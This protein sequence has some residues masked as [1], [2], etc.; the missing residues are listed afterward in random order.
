M[1]KV[2]SILFCAVFFG[3][4]VFFSAGMLLPGAIDPSEDS[5]VIPQFINE[6]GINSDF[7]NEF[8]EWFSKNFAF[9]DSVTDL[10]SSLKM[11]LF[12]EGSDQVVVGRDDFLFFAETTADFIGTSALSDEEIEE[13]AAALKALQEQTEAQGAEFLFVCAPNKNTI[14]GDM[15][16]ARYRK[17]ES[18]SNLDRLY[19]ALER[20]SV[21]YLDLRPVLLDASE[22]ELI[23][24]KRDTHW[25][26]AG[27]KIAFEQ[28]ASYFDITMPD[29]SGRGPVTAD[30][31]EGDLDA[32][33]FPEK[34]MYDSDVTYD[35]NGLYVFTSAY[36]TPMDIVITARGGGEK[37]LLM[38]R[39]SFANALIPYAASSFAEIR[40]DRAMPYRTE[41]LESFKPDC[42]VVEIA[43]RNLH[44]LADAVGADVK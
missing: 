39:D 27:A 40:L 35:F 20:H 26:G 32:L 25:N 43:E 44:T 11:S 1:T 3:I 29:L 15:M 42:V 9:C 22:N 18:P 8:E 28:I 10:Y 21:S 41:Y 17:S 38:F 24:H 6:N 4:C 5:D 7:G 13:T 37:K 19:A 2:F 12:A 30:N 33:L 34:V 23:Y 14:Y 31:F 16:P 36:S